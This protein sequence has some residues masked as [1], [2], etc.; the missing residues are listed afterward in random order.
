M[1]PG[2]TVNEIFSDINYFHFYEAMCRVSG[3]INEI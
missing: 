1:L 2:M 3:L